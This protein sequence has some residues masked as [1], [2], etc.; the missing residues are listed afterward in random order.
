MYKI[1]N[2]TLIFIGLCL[3]ILSCSKESD[4]EI[5][6]KKDSLKEDTL[7]SQVKMETFVQRVYIDLLGRKPIVS[8]SSTALTKLKNTDASFTARNEIVLNIV[9]SDEYFDKLYLYNVSEY[10]N[11]ADQNYILEQRLS[12]EYIKQLAVQDNNP[13]LLE[14]AQGMINNLD[15]L[16]IIPTRLKQNAFSEAE[17]QRRICNNAIYD[18]INMGVPNFTYAVF[19]S[20][21]FRA[22]TIQEWQ[23]SQNICNT[24]GGVLFGI[25]GQTKPDFLDIVFSSDHYFEGKVLNAYLRFLG[26]TPSSQE[27]YDN[28]VKLISDKDFQ[29]LYVNIL[30]SEEYFGK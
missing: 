2:K 28:T 8:E 4:N 19:E 29:S 9:G 20:F 7:V 5:T 14:F 13:I 15:S 12:A 10:L 24:A 3:V 22:P 21:L 1:I 30:S 17:M 16:M 27:Q 23:N 25:N 6:V 11:G 26:R 18:D